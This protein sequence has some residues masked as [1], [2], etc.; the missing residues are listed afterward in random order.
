MRPGSRGLKERGVFET[1][2]I[3]C[4]KLLSRNWIRGVTIAVVFDL[5]EV[6]MKFNL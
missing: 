5:Y 2:Q 1:A 4:I 3:G 6:P